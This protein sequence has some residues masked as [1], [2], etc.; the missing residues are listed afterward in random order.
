MGVLAAEVARHDRAIVLGDFN[1]VPDAPELTRMWALAADTAP[2]CRPAPAGT[3]EPTTDW[4][5]KFDYVFLRGIAP[6]R[7]RVQPTP[8]SDHHLLY[9]DLAPM[10]S[11]SGGGS[12]R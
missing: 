4:H 10:R 3:C 5:L 1:A 9:T 7:H 12:G 11:A 6:L 2:Q 8:N